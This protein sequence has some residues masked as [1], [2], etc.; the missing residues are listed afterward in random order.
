MCVLRKSRKLL[1]ERYAE[2]EISMITQTE[3][4][5]EEME[6]IQ[7]EVKEKTCKGARVWP[8]TYIY[9]IIYGEGRA[10]TFTLF[11]RAQKGYCVCVCVRVC[12][13]VCV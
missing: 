5:A 4:G 2:R 11:L 6:K 13:C 3:R 1:T 8:F 9:I 7:E 12:A 10:I